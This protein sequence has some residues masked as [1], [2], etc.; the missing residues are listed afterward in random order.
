MNSLSLP[1]IYSGENALVNR[2]SSSNV[3]TVTANS[4]SLGGAST[5][6]LMGNGSLRIA[7]STTMVSLATF[8]AT[9]LGTTSPAY[10]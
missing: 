8:T 5:S 7:T 3:T 2:T 1:A 4:I 10:T 9:F 6:F